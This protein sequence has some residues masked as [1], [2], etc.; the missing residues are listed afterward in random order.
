MSEP[1]QNTGS[2]AICPICGGAA[3]SGHLYGSDRGSLRWLAG[4]ASWGKN[5]A[6]GLGDGIMVGTRG[7]LSGPHVKGIR[8]TS[9]RHI[10]LSCDDEAAA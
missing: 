9:C 3:E 7:I 6:T 8:C 1:T 4:E 2:V 10:I 5:F